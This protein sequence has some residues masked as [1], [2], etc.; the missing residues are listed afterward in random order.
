M[1]DFELWDEFLATQKKLEKLTDEVNSRGLIQKPMCEWSK[2]RPTQRVPDASTCEHCGGK[3]FH[4][5]VEC[6]LGE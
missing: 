4:H 2:S 5:T 1:N 6:Y 3:E